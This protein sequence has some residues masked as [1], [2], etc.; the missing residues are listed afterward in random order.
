MTTRSFSKSLI[1]KLIARMRHA[2]QQVRS[3]ALDGVY[4]RIVILFNEVDSQCMEITGY[5]LVSCHRGNFAYLIN[6][7]IADALA[8]SMGSKSRK[9]CG[10]VL[11]NAPRGR[12]RQG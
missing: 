3:L 2:T 11:A 10:N 6:D 9:Y 8:V 1:L 7:A 4:E 12:L 5:L